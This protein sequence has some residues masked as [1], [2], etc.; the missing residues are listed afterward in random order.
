LSKATKE[1]QWQADQA[2]GHELPFDLKKIQSATLKATSCQDMMENIRK[3]FKL[4]GQRDESN[5]QK[6]T[7][8]YRRLT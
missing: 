1:A 6:C 4:K 8:S 7:S 5:S 3:V 2:G